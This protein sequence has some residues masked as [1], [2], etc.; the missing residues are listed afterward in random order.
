MHSTAYATDTLVGFDVQTNDAVSPLLDGTFAQSDDSPGVSLQGSFA[1][2]TVLNG[3]YLAAAAGSFQAVGDASVAATYKLTGTYTETYNDP[4]MGGPY[5]AP[6]LFGM[7]DSN[8]VSGLSFGDLFVACLSSCRYGVRQHV[9]GNG[10]L[11]LSGETAD[12]VRFIL[13]FRVPTRTPLPGPP[14]MGSSARN[15]R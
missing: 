15:G 9:H 12:P 13:R 6:G 1:D 8:Q 4:T 5:S 2:A 11:L 10:Q 7:D 3:T 14:S